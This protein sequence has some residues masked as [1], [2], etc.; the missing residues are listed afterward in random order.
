MSTL[1]YS[2]AELVKELIKEGH[3]QA[4]DGFMQS[5]LPYLDNECKNKV[6]EVIDIHAPSSKS[7]EI[8]ERYGSAK[9]M[10]SEAAYQYILR[11][12]KGEI[13]EYTKEDISKA[14][15]RLTN[16]ALG[17]CMALTGY[18]FKFDNRN[19]AEGLR[20]ERA[21]IIEEICDHALANKF[22]QEVPSR[23]IHQNMAFDSKVGNRPIAKMCQL[24]KRADKRQLVDNAEYIKR[25]LAAG[26]IDK[27]ITVSDLPELKDGKLLNPELFVAVS[28]SGIDINIPVL[29][30]SSLRE[31]MFIRTRRST[32][33]LVKPTIRDRD[34]DEYQS[35]VAN[36]YYL[37]DA[38]F[39]AMADMPLMLGLSV[40]AGMAISLIKVEDLNII[41]F[42]A[43]DQRRLDEM[44]SALSSLWVNPLQDVTRNPNSYEEKISIKSLVASLAK[45]N[46]ADDFAK[47]SRVDN[48]LLIEMANA[49]TIA[50]VDPA[51]TSQ[52]EV[53]ESRLDGI[54]TM[55]QL[56]GVL[57][58]S[59]QVFLR[60]NKSIH[61]LA[62]AG[63]TFSDSSYFSVCNQP[64][65]GTTLR[66]DALRRLA[67]MG[68]YIGLKDI[69]ADA[70][71]AL[72]YAKA[73]TTQPMHTAYLRHFDFDELMGLAKDASSYSVLL[74]AFPEKGDVLMP[75]LS[76]RDKRS[77]LSHDLD[78]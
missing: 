36:D 30:A 59:G 45:E 63:I 15:I 50:H 76:E 38:H 37:N 74:R 8:R 61:K 57:P 69:P 68:G 20:A 62:D 51:K 44:S 26:S 31:S 65:R 72:K 49:F 19:N 4:L 78:I 12:A 32:N 39:Y 70:A 66:L 5:V 21:S 53:Y 18:E 73:R 10:T 17:L 25:E 41:E 71:Q 16:N 24:M 22:K 46:N 33:I 2:T 1:S 6:D 54:I 67:D 58:D 52:Y 34:P 60:D 11:I 9:E 35:I 75:H 29:H 43:I 48:K 3:S 42:D 7:P 23:Y 28:Q 77:V 55:H 40:P 27:K 13:Q 47:S 64:P 14:I 56:F